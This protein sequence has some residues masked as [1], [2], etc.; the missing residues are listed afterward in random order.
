MSDLSGTNLYG[1]SIIPSSVTIGSQT[2]THRL[3]GFAWSNELGWI[4][5]GDGIGVNS[6]PPFPVVNFGGGGVPGCGLVS[7]TCSGTCPNA[8]EICQSDLTGGCACAQGP[9]LFS[10]SCSGTPD[11]AKLQI[12]WTANVIS[13]GNTSPPYNYDWNLPS[14]NPSTGSSGSIPALTYQITSIYNTQGPHNADVTVTAGGG[15]TAQATC[16]SVTIQ[17]K[18]PFFKLRE[19][20]PFF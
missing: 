14:G 6:N 18:K 12:T 15:E 3:N 13:Q 7:G 2:Y 1:V 19:I 4:N 9:Q 5:F 8:G 10:V 20:I 11:P 16:P 17:P